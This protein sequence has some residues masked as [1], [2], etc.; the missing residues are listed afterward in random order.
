[1]LVS[2]HE[3]VPLRSVAN[4]KGV[5]T[6]DGDSRCVLAMGTMTG[7]KSR[8]TGLLLLNANHHATGVTRRRPKASAGD[9]RAD[10]RWSPHPPSRPTKTIHWPCNTKSA[11]IVNVAAFQNDTKDRFTSVTTQQTRTKHPVDRTMSVPI[12]PER[13]DQTDRDNRCEA[14]QESPFTRLSSQDPQGSKCSTNRP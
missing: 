5:N 7:K 11:S 2:I 14:P 13:Q 6:V 9:A 12:M 10:L 1:M 3:P 8:T 4:Q